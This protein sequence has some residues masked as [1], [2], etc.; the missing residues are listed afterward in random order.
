MT[1]LIVLHRAQE[2]ALRDL[3]K[4][5]AW[6]KVNN[7]LIVGLWRMGAV[8]A[9][10]PHRPKARGRWYEITRAGLAAISAT[11]ADMVTRAAKQ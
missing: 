5:P 10:G 9:V 3:L 2:F 6:Y 7:P 1:G 4:G 11:P 8:R